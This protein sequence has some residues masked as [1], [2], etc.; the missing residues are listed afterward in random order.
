MTYG[1]E[2]HGVHLNLS[3]NNDALADHIAELLRPCVGRP[4]PTPDVDV[5]SW[6]IEPGND[7]RDFSRDTEGLDR[8][9]KRLHIGEGYAFLER[10]HRDRSVRLSC[11]HDGDG[12]LLEVGY[13]YRPSEERRSIPYHRHRGYTYLLPYLVLFPIAWWLHRKRGWDPVYAGVTALGN[14]AVLVCGPGGS[15]MS[16]TCAA[17]TAKAG[18]RPISDA[19]VLSDGS[20]VYATFLPFALTTETSALLGGTGALV[21]VDTPS[22][23]TDKSLFR[24]VEPPPSQPLRPAVVLLPRL[25]HGGYTRRLPSG[26]AV[27]VVAAMQRMS[28][29]MTDYAWYSAI[30]DLVWP[31]VEDGRDRDGAVAS[32][33][34]ATPVY[35]LG[36]DATTGVDAMIAMLMEDVLSGQKAT[37]AP[38]PT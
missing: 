30:L 29:T 24:P 19:P 27:R 25:S 23:R 6:W 21:G 37:T 20:G 16:T 35:E 28:Q 5:R 10:H 32:V 7:W 13:R 8:L 3:S 4:W 31:H 11:R 2:M 14:D 18:F 1:F 15:G 22:G 17:L 26:V 9:G 12:L 36:I 34:A 38:S 33:A